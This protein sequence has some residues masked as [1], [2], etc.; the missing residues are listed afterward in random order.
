MKIHLHFCHC[1]ASALR[2]DPTIHSAAGGQLIK[3]LWLMY[4]RSR[5]KACPVLDTGYG[6]SFAEMTVIGWS[7]IFLAIVHFNLRLTLPSMKIGDSFW[8][9]QARR[10]VLPNIRTVFARSEATKQSRLSDIM[11][12][13]RI[14]RYARNTGGDACATR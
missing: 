4:S 14:A 5:I 7:A 3:A 13:I 12:K 1:R 10:P 9:A 11:I 6:T 8:L 2:L